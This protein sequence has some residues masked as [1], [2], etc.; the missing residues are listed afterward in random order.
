[1]AN[2][3]SP[4][5]NCRPRLLLQSGLWLASFETEKRR[6]RGLGPTVEIALRAF[7]AEY[8]DALRM[9]AGKRAA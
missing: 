6:I 3:G 4:S 2:P 9:T 8:W 5:A 7:D 1:M